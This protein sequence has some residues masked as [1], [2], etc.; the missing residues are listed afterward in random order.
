MLN[1]TRIRPDQE[2]SGNRR[3]QS[4]HEIETKNRLYSKKRSQFFRAESN[5]RIGCSI[6]P[7]NLRN[8]TW[9]L[10][11]LRRVAGNRFRRNPTT[12]RCGSDLVEQIWKNIYGKS[13]PP[14]QL[15]SPTNTHRLISQTKKELFYNR[16]KTSNFPTWKNQDLPA[17]EAIDDPDLTTSF[18]SVIGR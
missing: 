15:P 16:V 8:Q 3:I 13:D 14:H 4:S 1:K 6:I 9:K 7:N 18:S 5:Q 17:D 12:T 11:V 10:T 2:H